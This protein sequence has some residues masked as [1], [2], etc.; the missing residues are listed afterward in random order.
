M[1]GTL[2]YPGDEFSFYEVVTPFTEE[3]GYGMGGAY[4]NGQVVQS[5]GGGI[6]QVSTTLYNTVLRSELEVTERHNHTMTVAYVPLA[7]DAAIAGTYMD[8]KFKNNTDAPVY[9]E[10]YTQNG[11]ITFTMYGHET[12]DEGRTIEFV[13]EATGTTPRGTKIEASGDSLGTVIEKSSGF[14]GQTAQLWKVITYANGE[15]EKVLVN[16]SNYY[17]SPKTYSVGTSS[18]DAS[19]VAA[20]K[21][22]IASGDINKVHAAINSAKNGSSDDEN[23]EDKKNEETPKETE[24]KQTETKAPETEE[25]TKAPEPETDPPVIDDDQ[26]E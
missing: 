14:D 7:Q 6:C 15:T 20:V 8:L 19:A 10:G 12:R 5:M 22:A 3:N 24:P 11:Q 25:Q 1:N 18:S 17:A 26:P 16:N 13:S 4:E 9:I 2:L 23:K 21:S